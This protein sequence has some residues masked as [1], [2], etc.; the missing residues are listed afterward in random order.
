MNTPHTAP[1]LPPFP[2]A[3]GI[4]QGRIA[5]NALRRSGSR[6]LA[7]L[8]DNETGAHFLAIM[9]FDRETG[10]LERVGH[11]FSLRGGLDD[12]IELLETARAAL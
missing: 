5:V 4:A 2:T 8:Y 9:F 10:D 12:V 7:V 11:A 3:A 1:G 6:G